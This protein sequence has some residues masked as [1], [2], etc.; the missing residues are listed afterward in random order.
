MYNCEQTAE[1]SFTEKAMQFE[2]LR[3]SNSRIGHDSYPPYTLMKASCR[4]NVAHSARAV[5]NDENYTLVLALD[6]HNAFD[7]K[8]V[9]LPQGVFKSA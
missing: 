8:V 5:T 9:I 4:H 1:R 3:W 6:A 7:L 2:L